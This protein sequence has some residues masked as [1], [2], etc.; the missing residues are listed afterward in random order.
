MI[1]ALRIKGN[2][3]SGNKTQSDHILKTEVLSRFEILFQHKNKDS[4]S[5]QVR[6]QKTNSFYLT[7]SVINAELDDW[8]ILLCHM[9]LLKNYLTIQIRI[10]KQ[11]FKEVFRGFLNLQK[12]SQLQI[13]QF[14]MMKNNQF[15]KN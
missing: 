2:I 3:L 6:N 8:I 14:N 13:I 7:N 11:Q 4:K 15:Q 5:S 12:R 10:I 9:N 1:P